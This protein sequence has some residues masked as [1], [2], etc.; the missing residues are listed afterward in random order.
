MQNNYIKN[1]VKIKYPNVNFLNAVETNKAH[2]VQ[3]SVT[4]THHHCPKCNSITNKIHD[5]RKPSF[6][7]HSFCDEKA[8]ILSYK[9]RRYVCTSCNARFTENNPFVSKYAKVS[10]NF[11]L[12]II[13]KC[14]SK[15]S[16]SDIADL[17]NVSTSTVY[18]HFNNHTTFDRPKTLPTILC[19]DEFASH[20]GKSK[21]ST[22]IVDF[23]NKQLFDILPT[24]FKS[25]LIKYFE[26]FPLKQ[27][28]NVQIVNIDMSKHFR[29]AF[30]KCFPN[31]VIVADKFH[32]VRYFT[33]TINDIRIAVMQ[34]FHKDSM[35]YKLIKK[36]WKLLLKRTYELDDKVYFKDRITKDHKTKKQLVDLIHTFSDKLLYASEILDE[37]YNII[38]T[39]DNFSADE[40]RADINQL[41]VK[42]RDFS[43]TDFKDVLSMFRNR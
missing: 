9:K 14:R 13:N 34:S 38:D 1:L 3:V 32:Y 39:S 31:A 26:Q 27:R 37:F 18:R 23:L 22:C 6:I 7:K 43:K 20:T 11:R 4:R 17:I 12:N 29:S 24:R 36:H 19:I 28:E 30:K 2:V 33:K 35:Q 40:I 42:I 10:N 25:D 41:L 5:Y 8:V 15:I 21:Y 16:L